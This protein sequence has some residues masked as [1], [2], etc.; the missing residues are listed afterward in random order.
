MMGGIVIVGL[1][2][3]LVTISGEDSDRLPPRPGEHWH[4]AYGVDLCGEL[5]PR[6]QQWRQRPARHRCAVLRMGSRPDQHRD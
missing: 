5:A 6:A 4:A 2:L 3:I 1:L